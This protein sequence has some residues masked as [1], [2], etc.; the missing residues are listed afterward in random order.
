M[1][2]YMYH[3]YMIWLNSDNS[4]FINELYGSAN[5]SMCVSVYVFFLVHF[6][7]LFVRSLA[8]SFTR[9]HFLFSSSKATFSLDF[10]SGLWLSYNR[11]DVAITFV[12]YCPFLY[13]LSFVAY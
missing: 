11:N 12:C 3:M 6:I 4:H 5:E 13:A 8:R 9:L 7:R 1:H 2:A 10:F